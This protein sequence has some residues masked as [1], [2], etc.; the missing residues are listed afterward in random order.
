MAILPK[1]S[2]MKKLFTLF[3][4]SFMFFN[5]NAQLDPG[6]TAPEWTAVDLNGVSH[7]LYS[8]LNSGKHVVMDF[9]AIWCGP[10]WNFHNTGTL[11]T[12]N[13]TYGPNGTDEIRV[14]YIE[15]DLNTNVSC[16]YGQSGCNSST[17]GDWVTGHTFNFI[18]LTSSNAPSMG[19]DYDVGYFPTIYAVSANGQNG[20]YEVGQQSNINV[21]DNWFSQSFELAVSPV[22]NDALC[23]GEGSISLNAT[24][25]YGSLDYAWSNG[26][27]TS[28][29]DGLD[30]GSYTVVITDQYGYELIE[31]IN[32]AG[33]SSPLEVILLAS[34]DIEC[35]GAANGSI[36]IQGNG[37]NGGFTYFWD[38]GM[39]GDYIDGLDVGNYTVEVTDAAGCTTEETYTI[40][41][42]DLLTLTA[43]PENA[44]CGL[45]TGS[46]SGVSFGGTSPFLFDIGDGSNYS[47]IFSDLAPGF[48]TM[49]VTDYFGC[50]DVVNFDIEATPL[51]IAVAQASDDLNC[52]TTSIIITG[53][54]STDGNSI[55][56]QWAT[57]DGTIT[58][59][60]DEID[61]T[62]NSAGTYTITVLDTN[63]GCESSYD[64]TIDAALDMPNATI[65]SPEE[66]NCDASAISLDATG[67][68]TGD[69]YSYTWLSADGNI[70]S[71]N[72]TLTPVI[73]AAG[74]YTLTISNTESGCEST[75]STTVEAT[76]DIPTITIENPESLTCAT[77][78]IVLDGT[79]SSNGTQYIYMWTTTNGSIISGAN[80]LS[81]SVDAEGDYLLLITNTETGCTNESMISVA[82][83]TTIP[84]ISA[85]NGY[86]DCNT[87]EVQL[88]ASVDNSTIVTWTTPNGEIEGTCITVTA[89]GT[90]TANAL[91]SNGCE[92]AAES[93]VTTSSD[94]P[95]VSFDTP[96]VLTCT[97]TSVSID[98]AVVGDIS[99]FGIEWIDPMGNVL[100]DTDLS[101]DATNVGDY[102]LNVENINTGCLTTTYISIEEDINNPEAGFTTELVNGVLFLNNNSA[103]DPSVFNWNNGSTSEDT[104]I[105]YTENGTYE[106]CLT[107]T[108][109]CGD[110]TYC[111]DVQ[112]V[113][114]LQF[115]TSGHDIVCY[116]EQSGSLEISP[117]G[118]LPV[119]DITWTGPN[120]F[121]S[122]E[123]TINNLAAGTYS[124]VLTDAHGYEVSGDFEIVEPIEMVQT[125]IEIND[126]FNGETNGSIVLE[127]E[128]GVGEYTYVW[129]N[130]A[131]TK[132][133][134]GLKGGE[135]SVVVTDENGCIKEFGPFVVNSIIA[136]VSDLDI[137][138]N[139]EM[140]PNP[141][142]DYLTVNIKLNS[143][144]YTNMRLLDSYGRVILTNNYS[145]KEIST[146]IDVSKL[147]T[148]IY[149]LEFGNNDGRSLEKFVVIQ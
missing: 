80:S 143:A 133:I 73:N 142:T 132:D 61:V 92:N 108:N 120:G 38:N 113:V 83:D 74:T 86:L 125:T 50:V 52:I 3:F 147:P 110:H 58:D 75:I 2:S 56:Y 105:T 41:Q 146:K 51:P 15:A 70:V 87:S 69:Q 148:G 123:L 62:V 117:Y 76:T 136:N 78:S 112:Y 40:Y 27:A 100:S 24:Y 82:S 43:L 118:G 53:E 20:V 81:P 60:A 42:P 31:T 107:V 99:D 96:S 126:E 145:T 71:G 65:A 130:E 106:I 29:I 59:G 67:S 54:G 72:N 104:E 37:G 102:T 49:S 33:P 85:E 138:S 26:E 45:E 88:C 23:P 48:Y 101:I 10:C 140:Y 149:Y 128:G 129:S 122:S 119:Y 139:I 134:S 141:A 17:Y 46:V 1:S 144:Q 39:S 9:S 32:I 79:Q 4:A 95:Q 19:G 135:Y 8:I 93:I 14:F 5:I 47:G 97:V 90:Y 111:E 18:N 35:N 44:L 91:A 116:G 16:M 22:V 25:G 30:A 13:Q 77:N 114:A 84:T 137:V 98:A 127:I 28:D 121:S 12:L 109:D 124:M 94:L 103:G 68:S 21:W 11:E 115:I 6:T 55:I 66:I 34:D 131:T 57:T 64:I 89:A 7:D 36:A 63:T